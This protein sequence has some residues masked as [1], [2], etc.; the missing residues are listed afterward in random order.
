MEMGCLD[1]SH[2]GFCQL[3]LGVDLLLSTAS[4]QVTRPLQ[5]ELLVRV[6]YVRGILSLLGF[7]MFLLGVQWGG[8]T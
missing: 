5:T 2:L 4:G 7:G 6:D 1:L 8:Y 3:R